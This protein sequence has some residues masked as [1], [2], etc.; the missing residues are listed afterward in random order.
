MVEPGLAVTDEPVVALRPVPG[1]HVYVAAP[2][3][4]IVV[5]LPEQI[6]GVTAVAVTVGVGLTVTRTIAVLIQP[7]VL[8]VTV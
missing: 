2:P 8:P 7:D 5:E 6:V 1:L 3:A 4:L